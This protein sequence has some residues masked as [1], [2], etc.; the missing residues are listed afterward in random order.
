MAAGPNVNDSAE[1]PQVDA[2]KVQGSE[3][4]A[5]DSGEKGSEGQ[6][7]GNEVKVQDNEASTLR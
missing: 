7:K 6:P 3:A 5:Q 1:H 4:Q 2:S